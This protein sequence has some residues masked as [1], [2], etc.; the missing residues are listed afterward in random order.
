METLLYRGPGKDGVKGSVCIVLKI[1]LP[2]FSP[3]LP[4]VVQFLRQNR[5]RTFDI[6]ISYQA[7]CLLN[8]LSACIQPLKSG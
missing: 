3:P 5:Y 2:P 6:V 1:A 7:L 4:S 8:S